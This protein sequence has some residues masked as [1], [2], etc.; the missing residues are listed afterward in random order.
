M[1]LYLL[2]GPENDNSD[3]NNVKKNENDM[4]NNKHYDM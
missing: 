1:R 3:N 4:I 2:V